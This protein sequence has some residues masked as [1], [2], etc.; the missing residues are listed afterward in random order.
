MTKQLITTLILSCFLAA[1]DGNEP[2]ATSTQPEQ[3]T[4]KASSATVASTASQ[5]AAPQE[6][7]N[8]EW[9]TFMVATEATYPP[10]QYRN[11][12]GQ[13]V[14]FEVELLKEVA[15]AAKFNVNIVHT[16]RKAWQNTLTNGDFDIW[17][18]S[19][20]VSDKDADVAE[21]SEPFLQVENVVYLADNEKNAHVKTAADLKGKS[22]SISKYSKS[23]PQVVGALTGSPDL[24]IPADTFYLA[25]KGVYAGE[26]DGVFGQDV[27]L[28]YYSKQTSSPVKTKVINLGEKKKS[29]AFVVK[30]GNADML[31]KLNEGLKIVKENGTYD[32]LVKKYFG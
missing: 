21:F 27:V 32:N 13:P 12:M 22:I 30:K 20:T 19:F 16:E 10:F 6:E 23:A 3:P 15:K 1:C 24:A 18:S 26:T 14:G 9:K 17:S 2:T 5:A 31:K 28:A 8:P 25:L 11:E 7:H 29:L 4:T